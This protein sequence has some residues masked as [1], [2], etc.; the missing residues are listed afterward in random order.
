MLTRS[1]DSKKHVFFF[2]KNAWCLQ[3]WLCSVWRTTHLAVGRP[4]F[5]C[6]LSCSHL[7]YPLGESV[8]LHRQERCYS[9]F[10]FLLFLFC[11]WRYFDPI[12][13]MTISQIRQPSSTSRSEKWCS[14]RVTLPPRKLFSFIIPNHYTKS[15]CIQLSWLWRHPRLL[16]YMLRCAA[17]YFND[18]LM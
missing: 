10:F 14:L 6:H 4:V 13:V 16:V 3:A 5:I 17:N 1:E 11:A 2:W 9:M 12:M 15:G 8:M 18:I 7:P